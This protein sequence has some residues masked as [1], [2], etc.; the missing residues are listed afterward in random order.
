VIIQLSTPDAL[1][2]RVSSV[3]QVF[4]QASNQLG[5]MYAGFMAALTSAPFAVVLGG[6]VAVSVATVAGYRLKQLYGYVTETQPVEYE[7]VAALATEQAVAGGG[8]A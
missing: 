8:S 2:G 5:S 3:N 4:I 7:P 1:R 6:A